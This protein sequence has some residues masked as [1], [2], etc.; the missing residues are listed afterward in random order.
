MALKWQGDIWCAA[1]SGWKTLGGFF[2][3]FPFLCR[4]LRRR[5]KNSL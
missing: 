2:P 4:A 3:G 1:D 5:R